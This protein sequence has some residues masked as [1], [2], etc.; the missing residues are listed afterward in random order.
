[1]KV[2]LSDCHLSA[3]RYYEGNM[4]PH[5]DFHHDGEMVALFDYFSTGAY[6]EGVEGPVDVELILAGDYLDFLN[7][8]INGDFEENVT[9]AVAVAKCEAIIAGHPEVMAA[10]KRFASHPGKRI[11]YLIG[12]HDADLFFE[13]VRE[14]LVR[15]WDPEGAYPSERVRVIADTDRID[16]EGGVQ[17]R[18]G[19]QLEV[20]SDLNFDLPTIARPGGAAPV[21]NLP[22]SSLYV[23]KIVN[24]LKWDREY[25]DKVRPV[26]VFIFL[27][28]FF[29]F[30]FTLRYVF[31]SVFYF[32]KTRITVVSRRKNSLRTLSDLL[33]QESK[34]WLDLEDE[35]RR[36]LVQSPEIK[37]LIMGH[38]H[39]PM[40]RSWPDGKQYI[41]TGTWVQ[42]VNLDYRGL[43]QQMRRT[44]ALVTIRDG[45]ARC[46]LRQ[47][48]GELSPHQIFQG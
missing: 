4:N 28:L 46:D 31:L 17:V 1:M 37:T 39:R 45:V 47:W 18:H 38:T 9:E 3:G 15:E 12:N 8:P 29:D 43:G 24:R 33:R 35:A 19:N 2:I 20:G 34:F 10:L 25:V 40:N 41:N 27:G 13:K 21:L 6:G 7:V 42:M 22:W 36:E 16:I 14:R 48:I 32:L 11:S 26:K 23:L 5:E 44:F 30:W